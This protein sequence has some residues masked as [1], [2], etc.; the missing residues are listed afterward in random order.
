MSEIQK[1][2][3][4]YCRKKINFAKN[5]LKNNRNMK[6]NLV[7]FVAAIITLV[8]AACNNEKTEALKQLEAENEALNAE[9]PMSVDEITVWDSVD[10]VGDSYIYYYTIEP[11]KY[12]YNGENVPAFDILKENRVNQKESIVESLK[13]ADE[14]M[15]DALPLIRKAGLSIVYSYKN[16]TGDETFDIVLTPEEL[17]A[18]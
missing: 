6:K 1:N 4:V 2:R 17:A 12:E 5:K 10:I 9:L 3:L 16:P 7:M 18:F 14:F 8:L 15:N 13:N 11:V